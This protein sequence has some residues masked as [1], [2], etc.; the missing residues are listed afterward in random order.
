MTF[1]YGKDV[2]YFA[3]NYLSL[4]VDDGD[5][6]Y[7][8][9]TEE[10]LPCWHPHE[11][12]FI[13]VRTENARLVDL[14]RYYVDIPKELSFASISRLQEDIWDVF[15]ENG[16]KSHEAYSVEITIADGKDAY[17]INSK[18]IIDRDD[19]QSAISGAFSTGLDNKM[20]KGLSP[21]ERLK[22]YYRIR[23]EYYQRKNT[24]ILLFSTDKKGVEII[25]L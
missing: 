23:N 21:V 7:D 12:M 15:A 10:N 14:I 16:Y 18:G 4:E 6:Y 19:K 11:G 3:T 17:H 13:Y 20:L 8:N 25:E 22:E 24:P 5:F 1:A 9:P 2:I